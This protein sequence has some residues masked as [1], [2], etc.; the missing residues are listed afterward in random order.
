M[1]QLEAKKEKQKERELRVEER[2]TK[3]H[4]EQTKAIA[5]I[6]LKVYFWSW[7]MLIMRETFLARNKFSQKK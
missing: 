4:L 7:L 2:K 3:E 5:K 6:L 1:A